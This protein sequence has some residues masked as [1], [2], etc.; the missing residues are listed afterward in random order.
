M[1]QRTR[2]TLQTDHER[3]MAETAQRTLAAVV[4]Q[5]PPGELRNTLNGS[6]QAVERALRASGSL[7][8]PSGTRQR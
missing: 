3:A 6:L 7:Q 4:P 5:L 2:P 8:E 1:K